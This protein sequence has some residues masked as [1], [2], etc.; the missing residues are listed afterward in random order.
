MM[1]HCMRNIDNVKI[2]DIPT[3][4]ISK[5]MFFEMNGKTYL[6]KENY[7]DIR[8]DIIESLY[9]F[10][11]Q[12]VGAEN[13]VKYEMAQYKGVDGCI[14]ES[15]KDDS[16]KYEISL[17]D[18]LM[19]NY[20]YNKDKKRCDLSTQ[21]D[22]DTFDE[23]YRY[24][25]LNSPSYGEYDISLDYVLEG[26]QEFCKIYKIKCD[27]NSLQSRL[28]DIVVYDFFLCNGDRH[29]ANLEFLIN[30]DEDRQLNMELTKIFDNGEAFGFSSALQNRKVARSYVDVRLGIS[31]NGRTNKFRGNKYFDRGKI[32]ATDIY[33]LSQ[34]DNRIKNYVDKFLDFDIEK[35][36]EEFEN[37]EECKIPEDMR[38]EIMQNLKIRRKQYITS[39]DKLQK[40]LDKSKLKINESNLIKV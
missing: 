35:T 26:I 3:K 20:M 1:G 25:T 12:K 36:L 5:K 33:E 7:K 29:W 11:L 18:I 17:V 30:E 14:C 2:L 16:T 40:R 37:T 34:K 23:F 27:F 19:F 6:F 28:K 8:R 13:F 15:F 4:G 38:E 22:D 24:D 39:V 9:S 32:V 10:I 31:E 21:F